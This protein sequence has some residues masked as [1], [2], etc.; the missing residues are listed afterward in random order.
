MVGLRRVGCGS[1]W[2]V[3]DGISVSDFVLVTIC[4]PFRK[5]KGLVLF[6]MVQFLSWFDGC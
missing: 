2:R 6:L 3:C 4:S 5:R 1:G